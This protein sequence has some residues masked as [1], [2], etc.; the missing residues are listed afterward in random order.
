MDPKVESLLDPEDPAER[1]VVEG[2]MD[3]CGEILSRASAGAWTMSMMEDHVKEAEV[4]AEVAEALL[5]IWRRNEPKIREEATKQSFWGNNLKRLSWRVDVSTKS[6]YVEDL[7]EPCAIMELNM[8]NARDEDKTNTVKF[9]IDRDMLVQM[10]EEVN[11]LQELI[12]TF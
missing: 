12:S 10:N 2:N 9:E 7:N 4:S 5:R 8:S 3:V 11:R 1:S 6:R